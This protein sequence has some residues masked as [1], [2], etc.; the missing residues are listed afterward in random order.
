[1]R[2][3][4]LL[5][6]AFISTQKSAFGQI[7]AENSSFW[8]IGYERNQFLYKGGSGAFAYIDAAISKNVSFHYSVG[9]G[10]AD[11]SGF[12]AHVPLPIATAFVISS[13]Y[14]DFGY[15]SILLCLIPEGL[16]YT[17]NRTNLMDLRIQVNPLGLYFWKS[18]IE[19][20]DPMIPQAGAML[21]LKDKN[22]IPRLKLGA[23]AMYQ[24][25]TEAI[26]MQFTAGLSFPLR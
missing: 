3:G 5:L 15:L 19:I 7:N 17:V 18:D 9:A 20:K 14:G 13:V 12:Y 16:S 26:G 6:V 24:V 21:L 4:I 1:M 23:N 11:K 10:V 25:S 2:I 8:G 22:G